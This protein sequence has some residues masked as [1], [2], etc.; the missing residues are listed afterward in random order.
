MQLT[1]VEVESLFG[2]RKF[3]LDVGRLTVLTGPN[4]GGKTSLLRAIKFALDAFHGASGQ[5]SEPNAR[6]FHH[7]APVQSPFSSAIE[8]LSLHNFQS[9]RYG[10]NANGRAAVSL[11]FTSAFGAIRLTAAC[12]NGYSDVVLRVTVDGQLVQSWDTN[13]ELLRKLHELDS[14]LIFSPASVIGDESIQSW[15]NLRNSIRN[16]QAD[17]VWKNRIHWMVDGSDPDSFQ[18]VAEI[19]RDYFADVRVRS[20]GRSRTR[21]HV[22]INYVEGDATYDISLSG[23]GFRTAFACACY[24]VLSRA[25]I[26]LFDEPDAHLHA[27]LAKRLAQLFDDTSASKTIVLTTHSP[28]LIESLPLDSLVWIDRRPGEGEKCADKGNIL[29]DLGAISH[30]EAMRVMGTDTLVY[31]EAGID[32]R[33][34]ESLFERAGKA[35]LLARI[36][37]EPLSG[38]GDIEKLPSILKLLRDK[39]RISLK[40]CAIRD[41]DYTSLTPELNVEEREGVM[42]I[43]LH[44]K[45]LENLLLIDPEC[46]HGA[47]V[48][49]AAKRQLY[50]SGDI[51]VPSMQELTDKIDEFT[52][53]PEVRESLQRQWISRY[54]KDERRGH[55]D[56][57]SIGTAI[58]EFETRIN[59][60]AW[61]R[62]SVPGKQVLRA[63]RNWITDRCKVT[64]T[65]TSLFS[66]IKLSPEIDR[67]LEAIHRYVN[68]TEQS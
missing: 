39:H 66:R 38:F 14:E 10:Q 19:M 42:F 27:A 17:R 37:F 43:R 24:C 3:K 16:G 11:S 6:N 29:V 47:I 22:E 31:C 64:L 59:D 68:A 57:E 65:S 50:V 53:A 25:P 52:N 58:R 13:G 18:R 44:C 62:K 4:N 33:V 48:E 32:T 45:E 34:F 26:L 30:A 23:A 35:D 1:Q 36:R 63:I 28:D 51:S 21:D 61:R 15:D 8:N 20:P 7:I 5:D 54:L 55:S 60:P 2:F 41:A 46:I 40:L 12:E 9:L 67:L 56:P 49:L